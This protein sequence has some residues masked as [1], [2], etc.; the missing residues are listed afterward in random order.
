MKPK[1][2]YILII[3][4]FAGL[5]TSAQSVSEVISFADEQFS[6]GN[7]S[8]A[9]R[10]YNRAFFFGYE[11]VDV[12][13]LQIG[14]CYSELEEYTLAEGFYDRAFKYSSS[15]S[16]KNESVLGKA[17]C[18]L[19]QSKN[20]PALEE[21]FNLSENQAPQQIAQMH[22]LKGIAYYNLQDD[23]LAFEEFYSVLDVLNQSDSLKTVLTS[24]FEKVNR[25]H[26][27][28]NPTVAYI[29]STIIPGSGQ[30]AVGA[31]K[32]GINSMIL[33]AGLGFISVE[34]MKYFSFVDAVLTLLPWVQ[35]YYLGGM[36]KAKTLA[37]A[38]IEEKRYQS[39]QKI[40]NLATPPSYR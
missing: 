14:H 20:L 26:R 25:Y 15:D 34:I 32:E 13:S 16:I 27:K 22:Y 35:R 17:F 8:I 10:E 9:A 6:E 7:Y 30:I 33:I 23:S 1:K 29:M 2:Y 38:K 37:L 18:L 28:F 11:H 31:Y 4:L 3:S 12:V 39:Y 40:I 24:E 5:F 19:L 36:E 21:L